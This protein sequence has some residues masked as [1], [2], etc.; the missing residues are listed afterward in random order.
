MNEIGPRKTA[1]T[2]LV[3]PYGK[4]LTT[5]DKYQY[6][7]ANLRPPARPPAGRTQ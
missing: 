6:R 2:N 5:P 7:S 4:T 1:T 3:T